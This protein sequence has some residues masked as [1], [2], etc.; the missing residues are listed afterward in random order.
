MAVAPAEA[1]TID[2]ADG[3]DRVDEEFRRSA[4]V[5]L[6]KETRSALKD[7]LLGIMPAAEKHF[8]MPLEGCESPDFLIYRPGDFFRPHIDGGSGYEPAAFIRQRRVSVV[9][10]LNGASVEAAEDTY[11]P[12]HLTFYGLLDGP[13]WGK[14]AFAL[15]AEPGLLVA[16]RS[17]ILHEV[18]PVTH[19]RRCTAVA[20]FYGTEPASKPAL[21]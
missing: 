3:G 8:G 5:R 7:R 15:D 16:F 4:S 19:G 17:T 2:R 12:G 14:C 20:W 21:L 13:Q 11:G 18:T 6:P 9:I 1:A 10:F